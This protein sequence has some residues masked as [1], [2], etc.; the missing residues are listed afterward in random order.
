MPATMSTFYQLEFEKPIVELDRKI[1]DAEASGSVN[2]EL[3]S[4]RE[5]RARIYDT[6]VAGGLSQPAA[7]AAPRHATGWRY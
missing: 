6:L 2:G 4:L 1:A 3:S 5:Q 7:G